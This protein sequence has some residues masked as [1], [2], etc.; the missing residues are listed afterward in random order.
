MLVV[1]WKVLRPVLGAAFGAVL[2]LLKP[3]LLAFEL[4]RQG[5]AAVEHE[6]RV[7]GDGDLRPVGEAQP[8]IDRDPAAIA[9]RQAA[10]GE[11]RRR[12]D[13]AAPDDGAAGVVAAAEGG[14]V[15]GD[16]LARIV[17]VDQVMDG[18]RQ[19]R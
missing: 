8:R 7:A 5:L 14:P 1:A 17:S 4:V 10:R 11:D 15:G 18:G 6:R 13:A 3:V 19:R 12:L 2:A 9:G 16:R